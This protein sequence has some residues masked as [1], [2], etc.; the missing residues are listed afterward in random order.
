MKKSKQ[1]IPLSRYTSNCG[2]TTKLQTFHSNSCLKQQRVHWLP[3]L[4]CE[5]LIANFLNDGAVYTT[6]LDKA[7]KQLWQVMRGPASWIF[8]SAERAEWIVNDMLSRVSIIDHFSRSYFRGI[9]DTAEVVFFLTWAIFFL[10]LTT[11]SLEAR[12]WK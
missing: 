3:K 2:R 9:V 7:G 11:R 12:R 5:R 8:G 6:A 10:F 1:I 4:G